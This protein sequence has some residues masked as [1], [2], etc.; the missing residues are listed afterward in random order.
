MSI[1]PLMVAFLDPLLRDDPVTA[2]TPETRS[3][4]TDSA[5]P[6]DAPRC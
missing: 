1:G 4:A 5:L 2:W 3:W 6:F